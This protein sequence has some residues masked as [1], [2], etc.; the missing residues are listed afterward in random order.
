MTEDD[1]ETAAAELAFGSLTDRPT[2]ELLFML[3]DEDWVTR[4]A[5]A[6]ILQVRGEQKAFERGLELARSESDADRETGAFLLRR[7]G[8]TD[9]FP[10]RNEIIPVLEHMLLKDGSAAVRAHAAL[11]LGEMKAE[12]AFA[13]LARR[14]DDPDPR[15]RG[16]VAVALGRLG[17]PEAEMMIEGLRKDPDSHVARRAEIGLEFLFRNKFGYEMATNLGN[18]LGDPDLD[19]AARKAAAELLSEHDPEAAFQRAATL[20]ASG[21]EP[22]RTGGVLLLGQLGWRANA[23]HRPEIVAMLEAAA[24]GDPSPALRRRAAATLDEIATG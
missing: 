8:Y 1:R 13:G 3:D 17:R 7:L 14:I 15:V 16:E 18:M 6:L 23:P 11:G 9:G 10:F 12:S 5:A 24:G 20:L 22:V 2:P 4:S 19:I 21:S